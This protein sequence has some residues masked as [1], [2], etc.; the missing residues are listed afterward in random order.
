M[1]VPRSVDGSLHAFG[2]VQAGEE[3]L[4]RGRVQDLHDPDHRDEGRRGQ[5][6]PETPPDLLCLTTH[7]RTIAKTA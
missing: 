4:Y 7:A 5:Y 3:A 2:H 6:H 1:E